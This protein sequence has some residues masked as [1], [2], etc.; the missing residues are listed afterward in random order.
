MT[1]LKPCPCGETPEKLS[2]RLEGNCVSAWGTCC[3][4]WIVTG[5]APRITELSE[6]TLMDAAI[7]AWNSAPRG[8]HE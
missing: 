3:S 1:D 7:K 6:R 5:S 4:G 8:S 2:F